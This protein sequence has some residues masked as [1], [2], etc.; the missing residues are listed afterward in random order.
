MKTIGLTYTVIGSGSSGNAVRIGNVMVDCGLSFKAMKEHLY[1]VKVLLI[2]HIHSDHVKQA[3]LKNIKKY[4]PKIEIIGNY[5]VAQK[6][7]VN[8]ICNAGYPIEVNG[9]TFNPF[10][11]F[12]DVVCYG[13]TWYSMDGHSVIYCTDTYSLENA[14]TN[15]KYD[16]LFLEANYDPAKLKY[17]IENAT[18]KYDVLAGARRHLS[19]EDCRTFY[20]M[21]RKSKDSK[22]IE[23][24]KSNR[25]Y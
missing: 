2:T 4:F 3:T 17:L 14:P 19:T 25:F 15:I 13:Y 8:H 7:D 5:E 16:Y 10:L 20:Y 1:G 24:H 18:F 9:L 21:N 23:L 12:H 6:F 11:A 22:L